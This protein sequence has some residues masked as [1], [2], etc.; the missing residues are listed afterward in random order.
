MPSVIS[1][2]QRGPNPAG[3]SAKPLRLYSRVLLACAV[4]IFLTASSRLPDS[5][6]QA[7]ND[8]DHYELLSLDPIPPATPSPD[9]FHGF[10]VL[11]H[12]DITDPATRQKLTQ[13]LR[14][15]AREA[16][17]PARCFNP[18]HGLR[19]THSGHDTDLVICFECAQV[20]VYTGS[21]EAEGF[22]VSQHQQGILDDVLKK[23]G[24]KLAPPI[25]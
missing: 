6:L 8:A 11:G 5:V 24:V 14:T 22:G 13:A 12:V 7:L 25:S 18:R 3:R 21:K 19:G 20:K 10:T 23:A 9:N 16:G 17:P 15:S 1:N 2:S 4:V